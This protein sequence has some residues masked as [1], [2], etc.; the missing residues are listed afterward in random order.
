MAWLE[1]VPATWRDRT[2]GQSRFKLMKWL[3]MYLRWY[4]YAL[5]R[6]WL[7]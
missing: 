5:R 4:R 3:P 1:E 6:R 7:G 2:A